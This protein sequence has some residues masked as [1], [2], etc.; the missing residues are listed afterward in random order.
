M[1][2]SEIPVKRPTLVVVVFAVLIFLGIMSFTSL[3]YE[4]FPKFSS[5]VFTIVTM[6]PGAGP[7]EVENSISKRIEEAVSGLSNLDVVRS[8]SQ[9]G[10]S[11]V[12]VTLKAGADVDPV[13]NDAVRKVQAMRSLLPAQALEPSVSKLG[14]GD[15]PIMTLGVSAD[16]PADRLYDE[17]NYRIKP[18]FAKIN[19]VGE[20]VILGGSE[21]EI[22][23]NVDR[24]KLDDYHVSILQVIA[25]I[26]ASNVDFPAGKIARND[27]QTLLRL[28]ARFTSVADIAAMTVTQLPDGSLVRLSDI[29]EVVDTQKDPTTLFRVNGVQAVGIRIKKQDE[30]NT[31]TVCE[32]IKKEINRIEN[33]YASSKMKF[34]LSNDG[35]VMIKHAIQS[36]LKDLS[37]AIILI[38]AIMFFFLHGV[39]NALIVMIAV[40]L[41]LISTLVGIKQAGYSLNLM[42]LVAMSLVIGTLVDDAIVVLE[43]TYRHLEMGKPRLQATLDGMREIGLSV[44][45]ITLVLVVVFLPVALAKSMISPIL[46]PFAMTVVF[47]VLI[48]LLV[49]FTAVPLLAS[50]LSGLEHLNR[51]TF[52]GKVITSFE[53]GIDLF[54]RFIQRMLKWALKHTWTT[55]GAAFLLFVG[56]IALVAGGFIGTEFGNFGDMGE[57]IVTLEYPQNCTV[58]RNNIITQKIE[59]AIAQN[60]EVLALYTSIGSS[61]GMLTAGNSGYKSEITVKLVEKKRRKESSAVFIKR[62]ERNLSERF[63]DV[64]VRSAVVLPMGGAD[65]APIQIVFRGANTDTLFAFA[66]KMRR[67]IMLIPGT[68]NVKLSVEGGVPEVAIKI[69]KEEMAR[70]GLSPEAVGATLLACFGG[71]TDNKYQ[72]GDFVYDIDVRLDAFNRKSIADVEN[73][74]F[75]NSAGLPVK[76]KQFALVAEQTTTSTRER[77]GRIP[78]IILESQALGRAAGDIGNDIFKLLNTTKFPLGI[79][80]LPESDLKFQGDAFGS[81]GAALLIAIVLVYLIMVALYESFLHPFVVLFSIPLAVIGALWALA[82]T[83]QTLSLFTMLGII[84][85]VGLVLKNAILVVDFTN[86]LRKTGKT[87]HDALCEAVNLRLRPILMTAGATVIGMF[88]LALSHD[89]GSE[90][91]NGLGWVL[92]GGMTSSMLLS[93]IVVPAVYSLAEGVKGRVS[94]LAEKARKSGI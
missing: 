64:N 15:F 26:Q 60:P 24:K 51:Q 5:P 35:S 75:I 76:L 79:S 28:A 59:Q 14:M 83:H 39:R 66:E 50:R 88:P 84:M 52:Q 87:V 57:G 8:I 45:S 6:Y 34:T 43:N 63:S 23:V 20:I 91:I 56:S 44:T 92:I 31:V 33:E 90:W 80:Y 11:V 18:A 86:T 1:K 53:G 55:I 46:A 67:A 42:T 93:L 19:G 40:P 9:E 81:L 69:N 74:T 7:S 72:S 38:A 49:A 61:S 12:I 25:S 65:E 58:A 36:V 4:L 78:S 17:L 73:L 16:M 37:L 85:L 3:K 94:R 22:Q 30:A 77:Y 47:S 41:S 48:S 29:A 10:V 82:L 13:V 70:L 68:N 71:N 21:R 89:A 62:L 27:N 2:L 54:S 32:D